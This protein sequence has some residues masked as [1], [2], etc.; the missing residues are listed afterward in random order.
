MYRMEVTAHVFWRGVC[1]IEKQTFFSKGHQSEAM[2]EKFSLR[3]ICCAHVRSASAVCGWV[4]K[5]ITS[6][7]NS[8]WK[9]EKCPAE[10]LIR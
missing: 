1:L 6:L 8:H 3:V 5:R 7:G 9:T 10:G 4:D 2:S